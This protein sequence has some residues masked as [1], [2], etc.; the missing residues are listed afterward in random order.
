MVPAVLVAI[1]AVIAAM[2]FVPTAG[3]FL[4]WVYSDGIGNPDSGRP[5]GPE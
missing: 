5:D 2:P 1:T 3:I 4:S